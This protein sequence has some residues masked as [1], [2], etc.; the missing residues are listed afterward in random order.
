MSPEIPRRPEFN[1]SH[2]FGVDVMPYSRDG[3]VVVANTPDTI[4][5]P[6][7]VFDS[8]KAIYLVVDPAEYHSP[9]L[10][11][12][13][14]ISDFLPKRETITEAKRAILYLT[15]GKLDKG[16]SIRIRNFLSGTGN[17]IDV[18]GYQFTG[19]DLDRD[20]VAAE[21]LLH[22]TRGLTFSHRKIMDFIQIMN[23]QEGLS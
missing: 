22:S 11:T 1:P 15:R 6:C 7:L 9:G 12:G 16:S 17:I 2:Y 8:D 13:L 10:K 5:I 19:L 21:P 18:D 14:F 4:I 23:A 20:Y 3:S